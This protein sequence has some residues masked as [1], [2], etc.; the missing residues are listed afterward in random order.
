MAVYAIGDVQGC[1]DPLC[2]LLEALRFDPAADVL[3]LTGDLVNRGPRSLEVLRLIRSL[4]ERAV[5]VLGNHDLTLLAVA[6]GYV[7]LRPKDTVHAILEAPDRAV[8]LDWLRHRPLLHHDPGLSFTLVHAGLA[9]Q[10]DLHQ[11][12]ACAQELESTL[13]SPAYR[14]FLKQM[15]GSEPRLWSPDLRGVERL[16]F[17]VNCLTR[18]RFCTEDGALDFDRKGPPDGQSAG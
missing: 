12:L 3:W 8:L 15:F 17:I 6:E 1:Y 5:T 11:A 18:I 13:R 14:S 2:R 16:R 7:R 9:P 10:W 4:G